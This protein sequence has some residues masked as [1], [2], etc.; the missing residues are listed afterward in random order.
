MEWQT[1]LK[2]LK[3]IFALENQNCEPEI[4][5]C[6]RCT[7]EHYRCAVYLQTYSIGITDFLEELQ[8]LENSNIA[9]DCSD[10]LYCSLF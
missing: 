9:I 5:G 8:V 2:K 10:I 7:Y 6:L 4:L 3:V 1:L